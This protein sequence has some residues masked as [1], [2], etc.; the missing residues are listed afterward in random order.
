MRSGEAYGDDGRR[1]TLEDAA[2]SGYPFKD[3]LKGEA[4]KPAAL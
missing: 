4:G 3:A 1:M 2:G